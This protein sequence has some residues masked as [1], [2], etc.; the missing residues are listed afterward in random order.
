MCTKLVCA[1]NQATVKLQRKKKYVRNWKKFKAR[2]NYL[3]RFKHPIVKSFNNNDDDSNLI[4][5]FYGLLA[6]L[7]LILAPLSITL[8]PVNNIL[9]N[10]EYWYEIILSTISNELFLATA[11]SMELNVVFNGLFEPN[12]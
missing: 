9:A 11:A 8:I 2:K 4:D 3:K 5:G 10:P 6:L 12:N 7:I 1:G